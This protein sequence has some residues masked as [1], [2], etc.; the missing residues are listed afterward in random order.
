M[1]HCSSI[2]SYIRN[3]SIIFLIIALPHSRALSQHVPPLRF[4]RVHSENSLSENTIR[5]IFQDSRGYIWIATQDG[6]NRYDG[7]AFTVFNHETNNP[8]ASLI[9]LLMRF[10]K[11]VMEISGS[12]HVMD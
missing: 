3:I 4:D 1:F 11:T 10:P 5:K 6:L 2:Y 8:K 9:I 7:F 12:V